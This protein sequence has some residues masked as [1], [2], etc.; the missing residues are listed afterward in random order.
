MKYNKP[1]YIEIDCFGNT[2]Y[3][4][5][6]KMTRYHRE[7]GPAFIGFSG[8][9]HWFFNNQLHRIDGPAIEWTNGQKEWWIKDLEYTE[10]EYNKC[11]NPPQKQTININGMEFTVEQLNALIKTAQGNKL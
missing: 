9:K 1:Q 4:S 7:D 11:F 2:A 10:E 8:V 5:N 6:R 3:Y